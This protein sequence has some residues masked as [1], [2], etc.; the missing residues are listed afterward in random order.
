MGDGQTPTD[1][2]GEVAARKDSE[3]GHYSPNA[4]QVSGVH[5]MSAGP[6]SAGCQ[7]RAF[8]LLLRE[9]IRRLSVTLMRLL[10]SKG[11]HNHQSFW[12]WGGGAQVPSRAPRK[13]TQQMGPGQ[14]EKCDPEQ[15]GSCSCP[16]SRWKHP[17]WPLSGASSLPFLTL[18]DL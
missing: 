17:Q 3:V 6:S 9:L 4:G 16:S 2:L 14:G 7:P 5:A 11:G 13:G 1:F 8:I 10:G 12:G 15:P 18:P